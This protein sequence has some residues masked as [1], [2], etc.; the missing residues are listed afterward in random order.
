[1]EGIKYYPNPVKERLRIE[2]ISFGASLELY[3]PTGQLL[4][5]Q[6]GLESTMELEMGSLVPGIYFLK[7]SDQN[8]AAVYRISRQ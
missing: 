3:S 5:K 7:V 6:D 4:R 8:G 2:Q 1:M